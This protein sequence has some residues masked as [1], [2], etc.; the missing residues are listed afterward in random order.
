MIDLGDAVAL[1]VI[2]AT[3][4]GVA[5]DA[6][7]VACTIT[8]PDGSTT[9]PSVSHPSTGNYQVSYTPTLTGFH[10]VHW[11]A[12]GANASSYSD[13]FTVADP[14]EPP[15]ISLA[16]AKSHLGITSTTNDDELR[17]FI[18]VATGAAEHFTGR[19]LAPRTI[20]ERH[21]GG[22]PSIVLRK[23]ALSITSVQ[24]LSA[25]MSAD[26]YQLDLTG[27][28]VTRMF[29]YQPGC[30]TYG[31]GAITVTYRAGLAGADLTVARHGVKELL[32]HLWQTQRGA[33]KTN[34]NVDMGDAGTGYTMPT[35]VR[36]LLEPLRVVWSA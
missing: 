25:T 12:T 1:A 3:S 19:V 9:L 23:P 10:S 11:V 31:M 4:A 30:W 6:T 27:Q 22:R 15:L 17:S 26:G 32:S 7:A 13:D 29:G 8:L 34:Y 24:Q 33:R 5:A 18:G 36:Q 16:E 21:D 28:I 14:A 2:V 35:R 20:I